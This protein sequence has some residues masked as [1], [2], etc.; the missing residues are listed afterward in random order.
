MHSYFRNTLWRWLVV[1][2]LVS[3]LGMPRA[4]AQKYTQFTNGEVTEHVAWL[5]TSGNLINAHDGGILFAD[6]KYH[7]YGMA[8]R[9]LPVSNGLDGGQKTTAGVVMYSSSDLYNW[10]YEGVVLACSTDPANPLYGPMRF[11]RPKIVY[12]GATKQY[13]MWF[14]YVGYPGDHGTRI[15]SGDAGVAVSSKINGPYA[16][17]GYSRP[18]D[19]D[20]VVRDFTL[21][22]DDD[23]AAYF[24]YDRDVRQP[25]PGF[26]RVL[27]IVKLNG[28]YLGFSSNFYKIANAASREA[29][30]MVKHGGFY[31]MITS[32][33]T[34]WKNNAANYYRSEKIMGPYTELGNPAAG[35]DSDLTFNAQGTFAFPV[36][37]RKDEVLFM[38]ER[39]ITARMTDSSYLF[40]P[41]RFTSASTLVVPYLAAWSWNH[42]PK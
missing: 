24:I 41:I 8:L 5:D 29:P 19:A 15:G 7:W 37:G 3:G 25:G 14:H 36:Q 18:I 1:V 34:G 12:N 33:E 27:H 9:P 32:A 40:L 38:A 23:G 31:Y 35:P 21:F 39:H 6:G 26:G 2:L 22:Q 11:E 4:F 30:V 16:F 13:V 20:G 42:W 17:K 10:S 28:D